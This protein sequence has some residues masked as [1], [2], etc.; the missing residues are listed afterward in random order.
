MDLQPDAIVVLQFSPAATNGH[1]PCYKRLSALLQKVADTA[2]APPAWFDALQAVLARAVYESGLREEPL[3][4]SVCVRPVGFG[5][6]CLE[7]NIATG[8]VPFSLLCPDLHPRSSPNPCTSFD[9]PD[10]ARSGDRRRPAAALPRPPHSPNPGTSSLSLPCKARTTR[11]P[12]P[13]LPVPAPASDWRRPAAPSAVLPRPSTLL[14]IPADRVWLFPAAGG[15]PQ[16]PCIDG[17]FVPFRVSHRLNPRASPTASSPRLH[18][19]TCQEPLPSPHAGGATFPLQEW[20]TESRRERRAST[21][22]DF[23]RKIKTSIGVR[24]HGQQGEQ[25]GE[26]AGRVLWKGSSNVALPTVRCFAIDM[27]SVRERQ[28]RWKGVLQVL[29]EPERIFAMQVSSYGRTHILRT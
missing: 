20:A 8:I 18:P 27:G 25:R 21:A 15:A 23:E 2:T 9:S 16:L 24:V 7:T 6:L 4:L 17:F 13:T 1:P 26:F 10:P 11:P 3:G 19:S 22:L 12:P 28:E 14:P 5:S 29:Q